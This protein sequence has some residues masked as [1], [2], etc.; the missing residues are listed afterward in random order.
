MRVMFCCVFAE[1]WYQR[2]QRSFWARENWASQ[3]YYEAVFLEAAKMWRPEGVWCILPFNL[4]FSSK[5][6]KYLFLYEWWI[7]KAVFKTLLLYFFFVLLTYLYIWG[8]WTGM[9]IIT[10]SL[11]YVNCILNYVSFTICNF[12]PQNRIYLWRKMK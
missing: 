9:P 8:W 10:R 6:L 3:A 5:S 12:F 4:D 1:G 11:E 2:E 7:E